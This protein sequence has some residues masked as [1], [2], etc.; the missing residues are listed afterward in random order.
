[1][2]GRYATLNNVD[3]GTGDVQGVAANSY[4]ALIGFT[5]AETAGTAAAAEVILR[6]GTTASA[7]ILVG[8]I[9]LAAD[10][11][12]SYWFGEYGIYCPNGI[13][14]DRV[15]GTTTLQIYTLAGD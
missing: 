10:G 1:M 13:F 6:H 3:S 9:N 12:N 11:F 5:V 7:P 8:P 15:A 2:I 4:L 14:V